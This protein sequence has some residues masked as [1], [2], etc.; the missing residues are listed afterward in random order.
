MSYPAKGTGLEDFRELCREP[1][2]LLYQR[3]TPVVETMPH[4]YPVREQKTISEKP[5]FHSTRGG[6]GSA[7]L[8]MDRGEVLVAHVIRPIRTPQ[9]SICRQCSD[10]SFGQTRG[11]EKR[12]PR[13]PFKKGQWIGAD[14]TSLVRRPSSWEHIRKARYLQAASGHT[15]KE[16]ENAHF[17]KPLKNRAA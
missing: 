4:S 16:T 5:S 2:P 3:K 13:G 12:Q 11:K 8:S 17:I 9:A 15:L 7:A 10:N 6:K 14:P 1:M